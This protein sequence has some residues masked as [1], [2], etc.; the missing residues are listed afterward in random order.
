MVVGE[1]PKSSKVS[2][3]VAIILTI[4]LGAAVGAI[5]YLALFQ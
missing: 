5:A 3:I 2:L 4:I 1:T